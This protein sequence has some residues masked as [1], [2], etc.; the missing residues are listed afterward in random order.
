MSIGVGTLTT[1]NVFVRPIFWPTATSDLDQLAV[2]VLLAF[3][4]W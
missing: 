4:P 1:A 2:T 3:R